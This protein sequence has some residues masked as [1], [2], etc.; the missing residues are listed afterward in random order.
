[1]LLNCSM[2]N[3]GSNIFRAW[4]ILET[5]RISWPFLFKS[6]QSSLWSSKSLK[7]PTNQLVKYFGV[8]T[9]EKLC[10]KNCIAWAEEAKLSKPKTNLFE[11]VWSSWCLQRTPVQQHVHAKLISCVLYQNETSCSCYPSDVDTR[12][13]LCG[14]HCVRRGIHRGA[15]KRPAAVIQAWLMSLWQRTERAMLV[16][17]GSQ[18][19]QET[20]L[21]L[22]PAPLLS[23]F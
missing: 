13:D 16:S 9:P 15:V 22:P 11:F 6:I 21:L 7:S 3:L 17:A 2:V 19:L 12:S 10:T 18:T 1:M 14:G 20:L 4:L 8:P 23:L 5:K